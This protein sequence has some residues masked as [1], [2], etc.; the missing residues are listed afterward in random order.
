MAVPGRLPRIVPDGI[1]PLIVDEKVIPTGAVIGMSAYTM[2]FDGGIWG[3]DARRFNP[4]RWLN[5]DAKELE[6]YLVTFSK[7]A[8]QCLGINLAYAEITLTLAMLVNRFRFALDKTLTESDVKSLDYFVN[9]F[10]GTGV[11]AMVYEDET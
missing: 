11:R 5:D 4:A 1:K 2:H 8:R 9:A 6:K 7:G 10:E 3:E